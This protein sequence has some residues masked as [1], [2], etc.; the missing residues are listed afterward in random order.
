LH[1]NADAQSPKLINFHIE[2]DGEHTLNNSVEWDFG[3]GQTATLTGLTASHTYAAAG[4]FHVKATVKF[5]DN[6]CSPD[7]NRTVDV[8][9]TG[10]YYW[11]DNKS[12]HYIIIPLYYKTTSISVP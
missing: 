10:N 8:D 2:Y 9:K 12:F 4:S 5:T 3:D 7:I 1:H 6:D 11:R